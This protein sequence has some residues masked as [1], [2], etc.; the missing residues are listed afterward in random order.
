MISAP[1]SWAAAPPSSPGSS[2]EAMVAPGERRQ[3]GNQEL[4]RRLLHLE[5][6]DADGRTPVADEHVG[7]AVADPGDEI[8][9]E[10]MERYERPSALMEGVR[11]TL[12]PCVPPEP[13]ETRS[14]VPVSRSWTKT[15]HVPFV[16]PGTR[17]TKV[18]QKAT[19]RPSALIAGPWARPGVDATSPPSEG[20]APGSVDS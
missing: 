1:I 18:L 3:A 10:T 13:T 2:P 7:F 12:F 9:G 20:S 6:P 19:W 11:E 14:V 8:G 4:V 16:S 17:L 5:G 15:S